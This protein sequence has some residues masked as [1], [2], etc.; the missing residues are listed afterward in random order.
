MLCEVIKY[1]SRNKLALVLHCGIPRKNL[2][3]MNPHW[4]E[5]AF[6]ET[7]PVVGDAYSF[8]EKPCFMGDGPIEETYVKYHL[9]GN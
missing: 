4:Y 3:S 1:N 5:L 8:V 9:S 7:E 2:D 6:C